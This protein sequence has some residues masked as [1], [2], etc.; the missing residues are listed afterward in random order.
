[1]GASGCS[2]QH[3]A[4]RS[5]ASCRGLTGLGTQT[6]SVAL[7]CQAGS[8]GGAFLPQG[9]WPESALL[10]VLPSLWGALERVQAYV[11]ALGSG[12]YSSPLSILSLL[13]SVCT[14]PISFLNKLLFK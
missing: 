1:M 14:F 10:G 4:L 5:V 7:P 11:A 9:Q 6:L 8:P 13:V 2:S 12:V 3:P